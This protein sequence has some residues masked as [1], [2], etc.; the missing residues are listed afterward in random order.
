MKTPT[1]PFP[2]EHLKPTG[3]ELT[4][5]ECLRHGWDFH[6]HFMKYVLSRIEKKQHR[7]V[8]ELV[9]GHRAVGGGAQFSKQIHPTTEP[10]F[11]SEIK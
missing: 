4:P 9:Q 6:S 11:F 1:N 10:E 8:K 5:N 7:E 2:K 3:G